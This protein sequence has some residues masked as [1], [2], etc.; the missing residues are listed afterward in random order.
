MIGTNS[1]VGHEDLSWFL[2]RTNSENNP[3]A[4]VATN[5]SSA[6]PIRTSVNNLDYS[7]ALVIDG[8]LLIVL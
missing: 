2:R 6:I 3:T 8:T 5:V 1:H 7:D 4:P